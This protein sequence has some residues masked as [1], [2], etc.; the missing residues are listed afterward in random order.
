MASS[1]RTNRGAKL[2]GLGARRD[3]QCGGAPRRSKSAT[4]Q[5]TKTSL[6][7]SP[8]VGPRRSFVEGTNEWAA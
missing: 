3:V 8:E 2:V 5:K 4:P 1:W 6:K 7:G